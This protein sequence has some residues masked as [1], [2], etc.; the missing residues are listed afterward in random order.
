[1]TKKQLEHERYTQY[2]F[3]RVNKNAERVKSKNR[4]D[5]ILFYMLLILSMI[6]IL[7]TIIMILTMLNIL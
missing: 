2:M 3:Y 6:F 1:M 7:M 4:S 5:N